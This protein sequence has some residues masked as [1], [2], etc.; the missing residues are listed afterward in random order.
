MTTTTCIAYTPDGF[1][2]QRPAPYLDDQRGGYVCEEHVPY[3]VESPQVSGRYLVAGHEL[4]SGDR[5]VLEIGG[6]MLNGRVEFDAGVQRYVAWVGVAAIPLR[7]G[8][9]AR[10]SGA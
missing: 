7:A 10:R 8:L 3:L 4:T 2:C 5:I 9:L 6:Q 1:I